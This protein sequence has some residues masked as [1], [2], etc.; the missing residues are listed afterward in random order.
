MKITKKLDYIFQQEGALSHTAKNVQDQLDANISLW[1][2]SLIPTFARFESSWL[3]LANPNWRKSLQDM[4]QKH[5]WTLDV[6]EQRVTVD[7]DRLRQEGLQDLPIFLGRVIPAT[8]GPFEQWFDV[9]GRQ[10]SVMLQKLLNFTLNNVTVGVW[11]L[12]PVTW[13]CKRPFS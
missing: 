5:R 4:P 9:F 3:Q 6:C 2:I 13:K 12:L 8:G 1:T 11:S 10:Y 7:E